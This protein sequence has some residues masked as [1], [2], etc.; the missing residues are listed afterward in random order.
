MKTTE[1]VLREI[2]DILRENGM[3]GTVYVNNGVEQRVGDYAMTPYH[4]GALQVKSSALF[5]AD[6]KRM[7]EP[8]YGQFRAGMKD[9]AK[10][11]GVTIFATGEQIRAENPKAKK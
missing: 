7:G 8:F 4:A 6:Y 3:F 11:F 9:A 2:V 1:E 10:I 5:Q